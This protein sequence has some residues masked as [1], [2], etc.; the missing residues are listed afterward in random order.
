MERAAH[1]GDDAAGG[2][3]VTRA[4]QSCGDTIESPAKN[5]RLC[6]ACLRLRKRRQNRARRIAEVVGSTAAAAE[7]EPPRRICCCGQPVY[8]PWGT[9]LTCRTAVALGR[10]PAPRNVHEATAAKMDWLGERAPAQPTT[11]LPGS[12]GRIAVYVAR[13]EAGEKLWHPEDSNSERCGFRVQPVEN[14][15]KKRKLPGGRPCK[16]G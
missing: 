9:C 12:P 8:G 2:G 1:A 7:R 13:L 4:C 6:S 15:R 3:A 5:Q 16:G 11:T 10:Y 14:H